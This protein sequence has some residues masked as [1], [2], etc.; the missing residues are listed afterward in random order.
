MKKLLFISCLLVLTIC[1]S[2]TKFVDVEGQ[3]QVLYAIQKIDGQERWGI[4]LK[5]DTKII[6][7]IGGYHYGNITTEDI[8]YPFINSGVECKYDSISFVDVGPTKMFIGHKGTDKYYYLQSTTWC[9]KENP[10]TKV[11][12]LGS[13]EGLCFGNKYEFKFYTSEGVYNLSR[14]PY[15][16]IEVGFMG[17]AVK[18]NGKWG[19]YHGR[20]NVSNGKKERY[21]Q[22]IPCE[23]DEIIPIINEP[24]LK[25]IVYARKGTQWECFNKRGEKIKVDKNLLNK[26]I[27]WKPKMKK[28]GLLYSY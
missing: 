1:S 27:S 13:G 24:R 10:V 11:E 2:C 9:A 8:G 22:I 6:C 17:Y 19:Y 12:Y 18:Q 21:V 20:H 26:A 4:I 14:G 5:R 3:D 28:Y 16:D 25:D 15:E 7:S 23:Y